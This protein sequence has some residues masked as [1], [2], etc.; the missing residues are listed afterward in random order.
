MRN[1]YQL[2]SALR[3]KRLQVI[4]AADGQEAL[5]ELDRHARVD[6]VLIDTMTSRV[7]GYEAARRI[8]GVERFRDLPIIALT[9]SQIPDEREKWLAAGA[10][11]HLTKPVDVAHLLGVLRDWLA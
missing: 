10:S 5:E 6:L 7:D 1:V 11:D 4:T 3:G 2:S 8:R 9:A